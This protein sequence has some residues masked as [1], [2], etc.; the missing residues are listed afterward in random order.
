MPCQTCTDEARCDR[1]GLCQS[2]RQQLAVLPDD[3]CDAYGVPRGSTR[4]EVS[5]EALDRIAAALAAPGCE[6]LRDFHAVGPVQRAAVEAF[7]DALAPGL[8]PCD[9]PVCAV[10]H[11][12]TRK[13]ERDS[14]AGVKED[15]TVVV[16]MDESA[17][18]DFLRPP[19]DGV[20][21]LPDLFPPGGT[22]GV[23]ATVP[24]APDFRKD[25]TLWVRQR[26]SACLHRPFIYRDMEDAFLAGAEAA[27]GVTATEP[28]VDL[29]EPPSGKTYRDVNELFD[30]MGVPLGVGIPQTNPEKNHG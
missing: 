23:T 19:P 9:W 15:G 12:C 27:Y 1:A 18:G 11:P 4:S 3:T 5:G 10:H 24:A 22:H 7:V 30:A 21:G 17:I 25:A 8:P 29:S 14:T 26:A 28:P 2:F 6:R 16:T 13:C 20:A